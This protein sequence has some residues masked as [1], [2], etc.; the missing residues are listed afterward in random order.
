MWEITQI[1]S[2][3]SDGVLKHSLNTSRAVLFWM[4]GA[5]V[6][7]SWMLQL[8]QPYFIFAFELHDN[9]VSVSVG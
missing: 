3:P 1:L 6:V 8:M 9:P 7:I 4:S 2:I 5:L